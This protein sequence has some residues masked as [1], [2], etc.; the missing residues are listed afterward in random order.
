[1]TKNVIEVNKL[2][3]TFDDIVA[4]DNISFEMREGEILGLLGPNGAGKTTLIQ[5]LLNLV[6]PSTGSIRILG[7]PLPKGREEILSQVNFSSTYV[8]LRYGQEAEVYNGLAWGLAFLIQSTSAVFYPIS[9][10]PPGL[11]QIALAIPSSYIFEGM[12]SILAGGGFSWSSLLWASSL[13]IFYLSL[14]VLLFYRNLRTVKLKGL[15]MR[16][17]TE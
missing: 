13:N 2:S 16:G 17:G 4:A 8:A 1:M 14:A 7:I 5:M 15:L 3:K 6:T 11:K 10:L 9:V 12:R